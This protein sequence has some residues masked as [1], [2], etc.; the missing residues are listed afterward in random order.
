MA[1][2]SRSRDEYPRPAVTRASRGRQNGGIV[3][4]LVRGCM[5]CTLLFLTLIAA[6][7]WLFLKAPLINNLVARF[8]GL[9]PLTAEVGSFSAGWFSPLKIGELTV[10]DENGRDL[11]K[12][13]S[14]TTEKGLFGW[15]SSYSQLGTVRIDGVEATVVSAMGTTNLEQAMTGLLPQPEELPADTPTS[16]LTLSGTVVIS[17]ARIVLI[18]QDNPQQWLIELPNLQAELPA[19]DQLFGPI[20]LL[21]TI[22]DVS[23]ATPGG[24]G[25]IKAKAQHAADGSIELRA[26]LENLPLEIWQVARSRI[27]ELPILALEGRASGMLAGHAMDAEQW[28]F[29]LQQ[30]HVSNFAMLAPD[31]IGESPA[32]LN[33]I[34][35]VGRVTLAKQWMQLDQTQLQCDV[36]NLQAQ[37]AVP[38]PLVIPSL[39]N[40]FLE[41]ATFTASGNVDLPKLAQAAQSLIPVRED[42]RLVSGA[43]QFKASQQPP[44]SGSGTA[45]ASVEVR[46]SGLEAVAS[47]QALTWDQPLSVQL[48]ATDGQPAAIFDVVATAEFCNLTGHG[49]IENGSLQGDVDLQQLYDRLSQFVELPVTS[50]SGSARLDTQWKMDDQ[51]Q[52]TATGSLNTTPLLIATSAGGQMR[53]P[54]WQGSFTANA[55][56]RDGIPER[57]NK[58]RLELVAPDEQLTV[59]L[60]EPL[61]M[62]DATAA[63]AAATA[64]RLPP[65]SFSLT[66]SGDLANWQRRGWVWLSEPPDIDVQGT[67]R[68]AAS[69]KLDRQH[70][71]LLQANWDMEPVQF[72]MSDMA[73]AEPK[74]IGNFKGR[75]DTA[76]LTRLQVDQLTV[77]ANSFWIVARDQAADQSDARTGQA[78]F[79]VDLQRLMSNVATSHT[80]SPSMPATSSAANSP[81]QYAAGGTLQGN[82]QWLIGKSGAEFAAQAKGQNMLV[83]SRGVNTAESAP[84]WSEPTV[85]I[86]VAGKWMAE[87]NAIDLPTLQLQTAWLSYQGQAAYRSGDQGS[88]LSV[89]G[90]AVYD[91]AQ[92]SNKLGPM[93]GHNIQLVGQHT[94]PIEV[95]WQQSAIVP[96]GTSALAGLQA[97]T[98]L[99]WEQ[100][101]VVGIEV[102]KANVPVMIQ[103]GQLTTAAEIPVSGGTLRWDIFSDLTQDLLVIRQKPMVVLENVAITREMC[104]GWLKYVAPLVAET[105]S[106]DGRLSLAL[107]RAELTPTDL[108]KQTVEGRLQ[109]HKAEVG[110]GPLTNEIAGLIRQ[111][112]AIRKLEPAQA[113]STQSRVWLQMP[114]QNI[115][116]RMVEGRVYH[117]DLNLTIGDASIS[118]AGSVDVSGQLEMLASL[119]IPDSWTQKGPVLAAMRGQTLQFPMRGTITRPQLDASL[120]RQFGRQTIE[121]AAQGLIQQGLNRGLEKLFR[122]Q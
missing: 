107:D 110:P 90:Q 64:S 88:D 94:A 68:L 71:E 33:S 86:S 55:Q 109:I 121:N 37:A 100:A 3:R 40:P 15:L 29:D 12:I 59:E 108:S 79:L 24:T 117:R 122:Q 106:I 114:Q 20:E 80:T 9:Q 75:V 45:Q 62:I 41:R 74:M 46:L 11:A 6:T 19:A 96:P 38:W 69:G 83:S 113:V 14:I 47:G 118:T 92:L 28:S 91:A 73:L 8:G 43:M 25:Q 98:H 26:K 120:M 85:D 60:H 103:A 102:G 84:L 48:R 50:M 10:R 32:R 23:G 57:L 95:R 7:P 87:H 35:A 21:A 53:E 78:N 93:T 101:R 97:S 65:A 4:W 36:G 30:V 67:M 61:Q 105:T 18:E 104:S 56:L 27:P 82:L 77:Q 66:I 99:G 42:T 49:T 22:S 54:N 76:D 2:K 51:Q 111:F 5:G 44:H 52:V 89:N 17:D 58:M 63:E 81:S 119:P 31:W 115:S 34:E 116:F 13:R 112:E 70:V 72:R 39:K 1:G 16:D